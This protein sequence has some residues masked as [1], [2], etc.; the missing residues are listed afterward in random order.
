M[1]RKRTITMALLAVLTSLAVTGGALAKDNVTPPERDKLSPRALANYRAAQAR[2][3]QPLTAESDAVA[4]AP[5]PPRAQA[6][7][8]EAKWIEIRLSSQRLIAWHNGKAVMTTA[9]SSGTRATP[10]VTGSFR[11]GRKFRSI[12]MRGA[13]YD[14][15]NVPYAMFFFRD[16]AIHGTYWHTSFGRPMSHGCINMPTSR[17]EWLYAWA[18]PGTLVVV[19]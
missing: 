9:I 8:T 5:A 3:R 18:P 14:L 16:Y 12:R 15:P 2:A 11:I 19:R 13:D 17:A 7:T 4:A 1:K 10:T 6:P